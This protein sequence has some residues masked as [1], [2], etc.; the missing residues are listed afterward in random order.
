MQ[1]KK[2]QNCHIIIAAL[3]DGFL[4]TGKLQDSTFNESKIEKASD[5]KILNVFILNE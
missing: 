5:I 3:G 2:V 1:V 4:L